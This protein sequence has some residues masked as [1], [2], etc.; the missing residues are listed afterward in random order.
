MPSDFSLERHGAGS[1]PERDGCAR[2]DLGCLGV[3]ALTPSER[4]PLD[5]ETG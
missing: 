1:A 3:D 4:D 2:S 5:R